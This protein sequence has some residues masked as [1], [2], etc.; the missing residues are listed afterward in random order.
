[1][2]EIVTSV[3]NKNSLLYGAKEI[4]KKNFGPSCVDMKGEEIGM[5][6][7]KPQIAPVNAVREK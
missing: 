2:S 4:E 6:P 5:I 3:L 7:E 1:M